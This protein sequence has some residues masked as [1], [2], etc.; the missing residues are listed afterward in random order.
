[1]RSSNFSPPKYVPDKV[2]GPV[3]DNGQ[4][5]IRDAEV[6]PE[7]KFP[8]ATELQAFIQPKVSFRYQF[9]LCGKQTYFYEEIR[10]S[11]K[12][13]QNRSLHRYWAQE[14]EKWDKCW[15]ELLTCKP[16][17]DQLCENDRDETQL[18]ETDSN[19]WYKCQKMWVFELKRQ[20]Q[21]QMVFTRGANSEKSG[22][23]WTRSLPIGTKHLH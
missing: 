4:Q 2:I 18:Q 16:K 6:P 5:P 9:W 21:K 7:L 23:V 10:Q 12:A 13:V 15:V 8:P 22:R 11:L 1:M 20:T 14:L 3:R 17:K 19:L